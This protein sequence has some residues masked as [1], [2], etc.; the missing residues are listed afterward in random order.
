MANYTFLGYIYARKFGKILNL[1]LQQLLGQSYVTILIRS[2]LKI[3]D[4]RKIYKK[5]ILFFVAFPQGFLRKV[6]GISE[7]TKK[8]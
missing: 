1:F 4:L 8:A 3:E 6:L 5:R 2:G 7:K